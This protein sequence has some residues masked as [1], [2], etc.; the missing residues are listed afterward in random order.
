MPSEETMQHWTEADEL[1]SQNESLHRQSESLRRMIAHQ[2]QVHAAELR[3]MR[4]NLLVVLVLTG[5]GWGLAAVLMAA[6]GGL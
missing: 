3:S 6:A 4:R 1:R 2:E 5:I